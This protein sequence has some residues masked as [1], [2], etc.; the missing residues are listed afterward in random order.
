MLRR[1]GKKCTGT[2]PH[3]HLVAGRAADAAFYPPGLVLEI[4]RGIRDTADQEWSDPVDA[5]D[6]DLQRATVCAGLF[7]DQ[8]TLLASTLQDSHLETKVKNIKVPLHF[9]DGTS[10]QVPLSFKESYSDEYTAENCN[11]GIFVKLLLTKYSTSLTM[12]SLLSPLPMP[13]L[14]PRVRW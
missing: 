4:L 5:H 13:F 2:H 12:C 7:H 8:P 10:K 14:I 6:S 3:Q 9:Q 11:I 1:L